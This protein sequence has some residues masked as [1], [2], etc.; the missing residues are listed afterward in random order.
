MTSRFIE[1]NALPGFDEENPSS[2]GFPS[3][4]RGP[5]TIGNVVVSYT[6]A[7]EVLTK[8]TGFMDAYDF[9]LNPYSGCS[10]GCTYCY[11]AFFS[12]DVERRDSW[13]KWVN[14]KDNAVELLRK[15]KRGTLDGKLIYMS[16]VTDP[17][18]PVERQLELTRG[19]LQTMADRGDKPKLVVQTRSPDVVRDC[20]LYRR[21]ADNGGQV[22]V[23]M[24]VTTDDEDVRRTFEPHC[25]AN[26]RRLDAI[27][28]VQSA[29]VE[30]CI[31]MT[32]LL[33]VSSP[34]AFADSL[35]DTGV[36][37]FIAQPF[38][39]KRGKFLAG[40]RDGAFDLMAEKLGCVRSSFQ[41]EYM[42][43]YQMVFGVLQD[44]LPQL[45]EGKSG[46]EPPF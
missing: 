32:P 39:F 16:S 8:A 46:F 19:I 4:Q 3:I 35:L 27:T 42:E 44:T 26:P 28:E 43:H 10:F 31:T 40:T 24:T 37:K 12:R 15:R 45:G 13:G 14:V 2:Q 20:D 36:Q 18:Q 21:I 33:L 34:Y 29:G 11:A 25:P 7:R 23:N 5:D 9:T 41:D 17:Y 30:A 1:Q 6:P 22:Q 38:H